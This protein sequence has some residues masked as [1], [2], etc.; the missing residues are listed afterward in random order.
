MVNKITTYF[1]TV[2]KELHVELN[3]VE[4]QFVA[5]KMV[6]AKDRNDKI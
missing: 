2:S 6:T 1:S 5:A 4:N 3:I